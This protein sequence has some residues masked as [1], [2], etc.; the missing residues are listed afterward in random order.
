MAD[1]DGWVW[2]GVHFGSRGFGHKTASGFLALHQGLAFDA[3]AKGGEMD[4]PPVLFRE[5]EA[6]GEA[7]VAAMEL[8]LRYAYAG[9]DVVVEQVLGI[10]GT[11]AVETVHNNHNDMRRE[12]H[13]GADCWVVRKGC[14]PAFPGQRGFVGAS[15]GEP[16][17]IL[18][19][20]DG[21]E[22]RG[23][24]YSTVHGAGRAMSRTKAAG[25]LRTRVVEG[26][27]VRVREG[28]AIDFAQV[29]AD[30]KRQGIELR[31]GAADEAPG[32]YKRLDEVLRHH[33]AGVRILHTLTPLGVAMAGDGTF[34]PYKD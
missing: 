7:Y 11:T 29:R 4:S 23:A 14:T 20:V 22:A 32:A 34:D 24:L 12:T 18:E 15:M 31:G 16:S 19:G 17:V 6:L 13:D 9:R 1:E 25:K 30:L 26:R 28:G 21:D 2:V 10:L 8:A 5:A 33:A 27:K 3:R